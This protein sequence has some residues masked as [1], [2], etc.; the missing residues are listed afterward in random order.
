[1]V[2]MGTQGCTDTNWNPFFCLFLTVKVKL[3]EIT[4]FTGSFESFISLLLSEI[5][6]LCEMIHVSFI[7]ASYFISHIVPITE[8]QKIN[9]TWL[10]PS[11]CIVIE[12]VGR[13]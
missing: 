6:S 11:E 1:M 4:I 3:T 10:L 9:K 5:D 7:S 2:L 12:I 13:G 8:A